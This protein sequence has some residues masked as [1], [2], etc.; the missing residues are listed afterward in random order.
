M[1]MTDAAR[2]RLNG[3]LKIIAV[4]IP[5][6]VGAILGWGSLKSDVRH[7]GREIERKAERAVVDQQYGEILRRLDRIERQLEARR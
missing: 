1:T 5:M 7:L 2:L 6:T 4:L 3:W